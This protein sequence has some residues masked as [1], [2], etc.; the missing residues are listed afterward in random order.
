[1]ATPVK[2]I[3]ETITSEHDRNGNR[4]H[5]ARFY[6]PQLGRACVLECEVGG[7]SNALH[8]AYRACGQDWAAVL[9]FESVIP[10]REWQR[11]RP[12]GYMSESDAQAILAGML[13]K[14]GAL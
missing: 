13:M 4:Y 1:M 10:K 8:I 6:L 2:I 9:G 3:V 14:G 12:K 11:M 5:F 7:A